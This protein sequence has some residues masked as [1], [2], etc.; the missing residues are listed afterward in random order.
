MQGAD[1]IPRENP[2]L[3]VQLGAETR[4]TNLAIL[5]TV[6]ELKSEMARLREDN[7]RLTMEQERIL[8]SLSDKQNP[9]LANPSAKQ[10]RGTEE[11]DYTLELSEEQEDHSD[12]VQEQQTSKRQKVEL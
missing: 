3:W 5:Q 12:N 1:S 2:E 9:P 11:R 8:K 7:A 10:Q 4:S 6:Q